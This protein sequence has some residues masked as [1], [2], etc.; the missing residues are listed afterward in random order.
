MILMTSRKY[1][2]I[3]QT[4]VPLTE[5]TPCG[6]C[7]IP[8]GQSGMGSQGFH[9]DHIIPKSMNPNL[10]TLEKNLTWACLRC[11]HT[12]GSSVTGYD[13][14][15]K[16]ESTLFNP[17]TEKWPNHFTGMYNGKISASTSTGRA[18]SSRLRFNEEPTVLRFRARG[19]RKKWWPA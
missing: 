16:R 5:S 18:T 19:F 14:N 15:L 3:L 17:R 10:A 12:K 1:R 2:R 7:R 11:N 13:S 4:A 8:F 6:Y 9:A